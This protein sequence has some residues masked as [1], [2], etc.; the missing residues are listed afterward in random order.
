M[1]KLLMPTVVLVALLGSV[2]CGGADEPGPV[3]EEPSP[4]VVEAPPAPDLL[5][6]PFTSDEIRSAWVEGLALTIRHR[7]DGIDVLERWRV[8]AA[9]EHG[10]TIES[11]VVDPAGMPISEPSAQTSSWD[12]LRDHASFPRDRAR[13]EDATRDTALGTYEGWLYTVT[14]PETGVVTELFFARALPGAPLTMRVLR[15]GAVVVDFEQLERGIA[16]GE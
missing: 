6:P 10:A 9:D 11:V 7:V 14:D 2:G 4:M 16:D 3:V 5:E 15:D 1:L 13:R 8:V 12:E